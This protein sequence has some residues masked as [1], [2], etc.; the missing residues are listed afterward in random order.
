MST[1]LRRWHYFSLILGFLLF[2]WLPIEDMNASLVAV[3]AIAICT[4]TVA[5]FL[6]PIHIQP[7]DKGWL[8]YP[9][10]GL[11]AG[12]AITPVSLLLMAFKSGLH[13]HGSPDFTPEQVMSVLWL[14]PLW[15]IA[16][17]LIGLGAGIWQQ[18]HSR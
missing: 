14:T 12:A 16:G 11:I 15:I 9:L 2:V 13:G 10:G 18:A 17:L 3:F 1:A 5:R 6:I 4:L 7:G 8:V